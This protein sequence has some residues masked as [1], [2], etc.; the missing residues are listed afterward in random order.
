MRRKL[1]LI[2]GSTYTLS[3]PKS[4]VQKNH[5]QEQNELFI[6]EK[7]DQTLIIS[8]EQQKEAQLKHVSLHAENY[9]QTI[10]QI[11]YAL[12][13]IGVQQVTLLFAEK[14]DKEL[15][16]SIRNT[17]KNLSGT[18]ITYEDERRL[19][20]K[21]L[22]DTSKIDA[23]QTLYRIIL[24]LNDSI[25]NLMEHMRLDE[26]TMNE[27][28]IDRLYHLLAKII[29]LSLTDT[30]LLQTSHLQ[31]KL[32]LPTYLLMS[33]RLEHIGDDLYTIAKTKQTLTPHHI[34]S[35]KH[36]QKE[37]KTI[38]SFFLATKQKLL[39][40]ESA[41]QETLLPSKE[42]ERINRHIRDIQEELIKITFYKELIEQGLL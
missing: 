23:L 9:Q 39:V 33:K 24:L 36:F 6:E 13:Y 25:T 31:H 40:R 27:E 4:W 3:L 22:L 11:I 7:N 5:L 29:T 35:L 34:T 10:D 21:V 37:L 30:H 2:A 26:A 1:Q 38:A 20:I 16:T 42:M 28:E 14:K 17:I 8:A 41:L 12:Y 15:K 32:F 19:E 18:E